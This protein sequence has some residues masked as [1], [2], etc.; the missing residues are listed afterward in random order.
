LANEKVFDADLKGVTLAKDQFLYYLDMKS[1]DGK[2]TQIPYE[3]LITSFKPDRIVAHQL[4]VKYH[5]FDENGFDKNEV[6][7]FLPHQGKI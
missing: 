1:A 4:A 5:L 6:E 2:T 3:V 7:K